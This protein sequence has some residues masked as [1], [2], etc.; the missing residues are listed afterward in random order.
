MAA[1][2]VL[3]SDNVLRGARAEADFFG[4]RSF[5]ADPFDYLR[6]LLPLMYLADRMVLGALSPGACVTAEGV[7]C[8]SQTAATTTTSRCALLAPAIGA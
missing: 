2:S 5:P 1:C 6:E 7:E 8:D 3:Y 4:P